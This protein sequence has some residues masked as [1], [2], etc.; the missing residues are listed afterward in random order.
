MLIK[1]YYI[2]MNVNFQL[3]IEDKQFLAT[4]FPKAMSTFLTEDIFN[5]KEDM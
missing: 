5:Y 2:D 1:N 3:E 4:A